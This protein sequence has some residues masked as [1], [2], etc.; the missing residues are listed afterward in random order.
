MRARKDRAAGEF[1]RQIPDNRFDRAPHHHHLLHG[2]HAL[3]D[4]PPASAGDPGS[5]RGCRALVSRHA[6]SQADGPEF[7]SPAHRR[8][9]KLEFAKQHGSDAQAELRH[10]RSQGRFARLTGGRT[11]IIPPKFFSTRVAALM[12]KQRCARSRGGPLPLYRFAR[13]R[14]FRR[15]AQ[16]R[17]P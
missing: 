11:P 15:C 8:T 3:E 7:G 16:S 5:A 14:T 12:P 9:N 2:L 1:H 4:L 17:A 6:N 13:R 10:R